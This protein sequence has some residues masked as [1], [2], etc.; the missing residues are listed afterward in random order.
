MANKAGSCYDNFFDDPS[1]GKAEDNRLYFWY[2]EQQNEM[3]DSICHCIIDGV[4]KEYSECKSNN[5]PSNWE[6]AIFLGRGEIYSVEVINDL[7]SE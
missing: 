3:P 6:D 7:C 4:I 5:S 1:I 2:S